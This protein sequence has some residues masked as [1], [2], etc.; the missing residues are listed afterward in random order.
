M[1]DYLHSIIP[2][3]QSLGT[4]QEEIIPNWL[5]DLT[6]D[7]CRWYSDICNVDIY[8]HTLTENFFSASA[9]VIVLPS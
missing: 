5:H 6:F 9:M 8:M 4:I 3:A 2:S 1:S 7:T